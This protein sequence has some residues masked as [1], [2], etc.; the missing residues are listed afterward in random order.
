MTRIHRTRMTFQGFCGSME[1][2]SEISQ[3]AL[4]Q[5]A[6]L[7]AQHATGAMPPRVGLTVRVPQGASDGA[8]A[9]RVVEAIGR[10]IGR[11]TGA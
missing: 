8:I 3:R 6:A 10:R 1:R 5:V 11:G 2:A 9:A 7:A 4:R